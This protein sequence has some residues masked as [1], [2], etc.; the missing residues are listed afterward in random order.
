MDSSSTPHDMTAEAYIRQLG[1]R[2]VE[3]VFANAGTD[4]API[5]EAISRSQGAERVPRFVTVPHENL[6]MAMAYG[7]YRTCGKIAGVMVHVSVGTANALCG[8]MNAARDNVP[9]LLA[10]GRTPLT[11]VGHAGSRNRPIHWGQECFDQGGIVREYV[12]WDYELR[13]GQPVGT[14]VD[15]ALDIAMSEPRGPVYLTLPREVLADRAVEEAPGFERMPGAPVPEPNQEAIAAAAQVIAKAR[16]PLVITSAAGRTAA[17]FHA[18]SELAS[19]FALPVVHS[20]AQDLCVSTDHEMH[21]GFDASPALLEQADA[22]IL[23]DCKV[24]WIPKITGPRPE[25]KVIHISGDPL[26]S[27][28]PFIGFKYDVLV[29]GGVPASLRSLH[30][31]LQSEI[32]GD[33]GAVGERRA[34]VGALRAAYLEKR[35]E[36]LAA[37]AKKVPIS[38]AHISGCLNT[39]KADTAVCLSELGMPTGLLNL[40]EPQTLIGGTQAGGL[41]LGLGAALGAKMA[42]PEREV[43]VAVGD[44]SY[45]FGN[46]LPYHFVQQA[47][48]LPTLTIIANNSSWHAVRAATLHIYP[49]GKAANANQMP[50]TE[51]APSPAYEK[52][53][54][55]IG[56]LGLRVDH[57]DDL[58]EALKTGLEAVRAGTPALVNVIT[59]ARA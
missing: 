59:Q 18:L 21:L 6:A 1:R 12:K 23:I 3:V 11:E 49:D 52:T 14:V 33:G 54:E 13:A 45:M 39:L 19:T 8:L 10:S 50:L 4:F 35:A 17:G 56:G 20:D 28:Y 42:A 53:I 7:Y 41:G 43:I 26:I 36:A 55:T 57:P 46:P 40:R 51:L 15:R 9:I 37:A 16:F 22:I 32:G 25:A 27:S 29:A 5:I 30:A 24:P 31:L 48:K 58:M 2:G 38:N 34:R 44:G 47:E